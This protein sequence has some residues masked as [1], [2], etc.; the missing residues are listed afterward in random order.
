MVWILILWVKLMAG[1][2]ATQDQRP[3]ENPLEG[4]SFQ[5]KQTKISSTTI[6]YSPE[7]PEEDSE[8]T[9]DETDSAYMSTEHLGALIFDFFRSTCHFFVYQDRL[10]QAHINPILTPPDTYT[11]F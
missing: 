2:C 9:D 5:T 10:S 7:N 6:H 4:Y 1:L 3:L 8:D 11:R